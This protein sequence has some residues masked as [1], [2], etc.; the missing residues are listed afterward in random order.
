MIKVIRVKSVPGGLR[1][2]L[3]P[4]DRKVIPVFRVQWVLRG[5]KATPVL[6]A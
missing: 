6:R 5:L 3:V 1:V 4:R 2:P